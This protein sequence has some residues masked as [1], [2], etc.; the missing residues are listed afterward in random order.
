M[1]SFLHGFWGLDSDLH[2]CKT[3]TLLTGR[4]PRPHIQFLP[5]S[6]IYQ[7]ID[8]G[9]LRTCTHGTGDVGHYRRLKVAESLA[10]NHISFVHGPD[11]P[12][13]LTPRSSV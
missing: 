10:I 8:V 7:K 4:L 11:V 5:Y 2:A 1:P 13:L 6:Y 12:A 3:S 9:F